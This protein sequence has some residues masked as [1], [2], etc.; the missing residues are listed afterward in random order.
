MDLNDE[1]KEL[2]EGF[3]NSLAQVPTEELS[4]LLSSSF[5]WAGSKI[6]WKTAK[7]H[8][9]KKMIDLQ[10]HNEVEQFI[11]KTNIS[12]TILDSKHI[13]YV[14]DG[15]LDFGLIIKPEIFFDILHIIYENVPLHHYFFDN[16]ATWCLAI[17]AEGYID[18]GY[19]IKAKK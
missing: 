15:P 9:Y 17:T 14:N 6:D 12:R 19:S 4:D 7:D 8:Q 13:C 11:I 1:V 3:T 16:K 5:E 2:I 18:F 10:S